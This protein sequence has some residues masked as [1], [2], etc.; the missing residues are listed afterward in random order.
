VEVLLGVA[1]VLFV[2]FAVAS[3]DLVCKYLCFALVALS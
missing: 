3:V 1:S 2:S